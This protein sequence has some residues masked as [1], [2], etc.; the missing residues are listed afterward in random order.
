MG[1]TAD[2]TFGKKYQEIAKKYVGEEITESPE[3]LF[4]AY[5]FKTE[6]AKY[7]VKADRLAHRYGCRTMFIEY[8]CSGKPSGIRT[9]D[10]DF[11]FYFMVKPSGEYKVYKIPLKILKDECT[12]GLRMVSGG[13]GGRVRGHIISVEKLQE[14][15]LE[16]LL[17]GVP[18]E[19]KSCLVF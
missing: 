14:Y 16:M 2:L 15:E 5:D 7:E 17:P 18:S 9:S 6:T 12:K 1:F 11:W 3:G 19:E 13:D 8:E 10:A 4:K